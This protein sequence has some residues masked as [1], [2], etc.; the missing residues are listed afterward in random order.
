MLGW[1]CI[2]INSETL[3]GLKKEDS[4]EKKKILTTNSLSY[5]ADSFNLHWSFIIPKHPFLFI[6]FEPG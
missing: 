1:E 3:T 6:S 2:E 5:F 4:A